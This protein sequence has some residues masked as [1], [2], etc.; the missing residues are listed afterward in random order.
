MLKSSPA[1]DLINLADNSFNKTANGS[2]LIDLGSEIGCMVVKNLSHIPGGV[3]IVS[4]LMDM[5]NAQQI[6][7]DTEFLYRKLEEGKTF[8]EMTTLMEEVHNEFKL[9]AHKGLLYE[10]IFR[11]I[12]LIVVIAIMVVCF[13]RRCK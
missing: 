9:N 2:K 1:Y 5:E 10:K 4:G 6:K 7:T 12:I 8:N 3:S 11:C 13:I